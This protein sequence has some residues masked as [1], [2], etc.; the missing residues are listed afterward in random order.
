MREFNKLVRDFIPDII[1]RAG[2]VAE[3]RPY[4]AL[5]FRFALLEK[6]IEESD[7]FVEA[8]EYEVD[9]LL[10]EAADCKEVYDYISAEWHVGLGALVIAPKRLRVVAADPREELARLARRM[11]DA[12]HD[13]AALVGATADYRNA[14][15]IVIN[16]FFLFDKLYERQIAR[17]K[18]R[19]QFSRRLCLIR[20]YNKEESTRM[21]AAP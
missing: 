14:F 16:H 21:H 5:E 9:A 12:S 20:T 13:H 2:D 1:E 4:D 19:G 8:G 6:L 10:S 15:D 17:A 18:E 7:E 11:L 3:V